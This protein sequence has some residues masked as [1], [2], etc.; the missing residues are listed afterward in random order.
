MSSAAPHS[1]A[2]ARPPAGGA[3]STAERGGL[4]ELASGPAALAI[5]VWGASFVATRKAL[6]GFPPGMLVAARFAIGAAFIAG[7]Q[8]AR[9]RPVLPE[10]ADF[11]RCVALGLLLAVH[12]GVQAIALR[13]TSATHSGWLVAFSPVA[14]ALGAALFLRERIA[15]RAWLGIAVAASG[16][17]LVVLSR[18]QGLENARVGDL[19]VLST[20][21]SWATYTLLSRAALARSGA[22]RVT[23]LCMAVAAL[24]STAAA[25]AE[26]RTE[27][28]PDASAWLALVF[29]GLGSSGIGFTAW[30]SAIERHGATR[31]GVLLYFQPFVTLVLSWLLLGEAIDATSIAG[32]ALVLL[33][34][35]GVARRR[36]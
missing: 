17:A 8:L 11:G 18:S 24:V 34:V 30:A 19:F 15:A 4:L 7:L 23:P 9:R 1:S 5:F 25:F 26:P 3:V 29:L 13:Y 21:A 27:L 14:I 35:A 28:V 20:C 12:I 2:A 6:A 16:V 33:G 22:W 32:G 10:R 36:G 31:A